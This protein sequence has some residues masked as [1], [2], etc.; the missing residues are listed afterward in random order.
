MIN[1][2]CIVLAF[3]FLSAQSVFPM[4]CL[5]ERIRKMFG[6]RTNRHPDQPIYGDRNKIG[7]E[8]W[9]RAAAKRTNKKAE[10]EDRR[11]IEQ[12]EEQR[13]KALL[14]EYNR[15]LLLQATKDGN[16]V[17]V[18]NS[19]S[20]MQSDID[21][22]IQIQIDVCS[23]RDGSARRQILL[24]N[25]TLNY[26]SDFHELTPV[27]I[28]SLHGHVGV[29]EK[30]V[31][32]LQSRV[33]A[34]TSKTYF[35]S[36]FLEVLQAIM[37]CVDLAGKTPLMIAVIAE[38]YG[39][40]VYLLELCV[41]DKKVVDVNAT[42]ENAWYALIDAEWKGHKEIADLLRQNGADGAQR[43]ILGLSADALHYGF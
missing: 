28:A 5:T 30:I 38:Q 29:I 14:A 12:E 11:K 21:E 41:D 35:N 27:M 10:E 26:R 40:V 13:Q 18:E 9:E 39:A 8:F 42:D 23:G 37:N 16:I 32:F 25:R 31:V 34:L 36:V 15:N 19:L 3:I 20:A 1:K 33:R 24:L 4:D 2:V 7:E 6:N 17:E 22:M 43:D